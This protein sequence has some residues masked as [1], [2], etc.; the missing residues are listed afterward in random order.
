M[1]K[2]EKRLD[3]IR[4]NPRHVTFDDLRI[5]LEDHGFERK[6]GKGTSHHVYRAEID[7]QVWTLT[8]PFKRPHL[9]ATYVKQAL[10]AIDAIRAIIV[11][12][13]EANGEDRDA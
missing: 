2:R 5:L 4:Q 12:N 1:T 3:K 13:D 6:G 11:E 8:I 10:L 7:G 9:N